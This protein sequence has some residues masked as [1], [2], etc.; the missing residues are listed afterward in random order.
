MPVHRLRTVHLI[1][2]C[3]RQVDF[4]LLECAVE[5]LHGQGG[6]LRV[7]CFARLLEAQRLHRRVR[8]QRLGQHVNVLGS[9]AGE[10][11][12]RDGP[13][14]AQQPREERKG[15]LRA[16]HVL[17]LQVDRRVRGWPV[18]LEPVRVAVARAPLKVLHE[19]IP[20]F[21]ALVVANV[22][23]RNVERLES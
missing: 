5:L 10:G 23:V 1:A 19:C 2:A 20:D 13:V 14:C 17:L 21:L 11:E 18:L 16:D 22:A 4:G 7:G 15:P 9:Q 3:K 12:A 6:D 8:C